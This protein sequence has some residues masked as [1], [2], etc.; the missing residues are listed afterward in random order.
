MMNNQVNAPN[1]FPSNS[2]RRFVQRRLLVLGLYL[3]YA[4]SIVGWWSTWGVKGTSVVERLLGS[5]ILHFEILI[6]LIPTAACMT[7]FIMLLSSNIARMTRARDKHLDEH[8]RMVRGRASRYAYSV[9]AVLL[10]VVTW[11][12]G[13]VPT[14][15]ARLGLDWP[16]LTNPLQGMA[17]LWTVILIVLTLPISIITWMERE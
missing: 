15:S 9:I 10:I 16:M 11:Y 2:R 14:L 7:L 5:W 8:L 3:S 6:P 17:L 13:F 12:L 4:L 1:D